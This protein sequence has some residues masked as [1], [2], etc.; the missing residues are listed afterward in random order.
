V[1]LAHAGAVFAAAALLL[2]GCSGD[3]TGSPPGDGGPGSDAGERPP[4]SAGHDLVFHDALGVVLLV[5]AGLGGTTS[6]P[7]TQPGQLW[8]WNG[9]RW[10]LLDSSGPPI[11]NLG[12]VAYDAAREVLVIHGGGYSAQLSYGDTWEWRAD[13]GWAHIDVP[14]PGIRDHTQMTYDTV[15][16]QV[17]LFGGQRDVV[18]FPDDTWVWDGGQW[19]ASSTPAPG[20][21]VHHAMQFD[22]DAGVVVVFGGSEGGVTDRGDTW[23]WNGTS[24]TE[25]LPEQTARTHARMAFDESRG[26]LVLVGG[27]TASTPTL[28]RE[29]AGWVPLAVPGGPSPRYLPG[30]A[31]D[32]ARGVLVVFGGG[33]PT[34]TA[35]FADTWELGPTSWTRRDPP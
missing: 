11:R 21:R 6:P 2:S 7:S 9:T 27:G 20:G 4:P 15:R 14:G 25:L 31:Y 1:R 3:N 29:A 35:L 8:A 19:S 16:R 33:D 24:W 26:A 23:G 18:T 28:V 17:L 30:V 22:P 5:N 12:G 13:A 32:R 10:R 34:S